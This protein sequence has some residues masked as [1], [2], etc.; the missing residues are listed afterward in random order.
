M[1][2]CTWVAALCL[3][4]SIISA[5]VPH[6]F[7]QNFMH[8][9]GCVRN[10]CLARH[11]DCTS[12]ESVSLARSSHIH[13]APSTAGTRSRQCLSL[14]NTFSTAAPTGTSLGTM[15]SVFLKLQATLSFNCRLVGTAFNHTITAFM[16]SVHVASIACAGLD[17]QA[18]A[19]HQI[20][21][22]LP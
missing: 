14:H 21:I 5:A 19:N 11:F 7:D 20:K 12:T 22:S 18:A 3:S 9:A 16:I 17:P 15:I 4:S 10:R 6:P 1:T 8:V 13:C 2:A